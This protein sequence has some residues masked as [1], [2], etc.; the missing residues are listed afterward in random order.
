MV[1]SP[2]HRFDILAGEDGARLRR[3]MFRLKGEDGTGA[4]SSGRTTTD[5]VDHDESGPSLGVEERVDFCSIF[6]FGDSMVG[7]FSTHR[8]DHLFRVRHLGFLSG[9][10]SIST[11]Y[12]DG[13][14]ERRSINRTRP[15]LRGWSISC[16]QGQ[17]ALPH[18]HW[19][20]NW[21]RSIREIRRGCQK[22]G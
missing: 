3:S 13:N 19:N 5:T 10:W 17:A 21:N 7:E 16:R 18:P 11:S 14:R 9:G 22:P 1:A 6:Q 15:G 4:R 12:P 20:S 8:S 2:F